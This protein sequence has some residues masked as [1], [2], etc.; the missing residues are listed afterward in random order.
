MWQ[1]IRGESS[2]SNGIGWIFPREF[3]RE[4]GRK[5]GRPF[6]NQRP[7]ELLGGRKVDGKRRRAEQLGGGGCVPRISPSEISRKISRT[8]KN[9]ERRRAL[10]ERGRKS[11]STD[12]VGRSPT[13]DRRCRRRRGWRTNLGLG[14]ASPAASQG[15]LAAH[16]PLPG[17]SIPPPHEKMPCAVVHTP[18]PT[19]PRPRSQ[20]SL[21]PPRPATPAD[22]K[23]HSPCQAPFART[24]RSFAP[25]ERRRF[26][27]AQVTDQ[28]V[29]QARSVAAWRRPNSR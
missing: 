3:P 28:R 26:R 9:S 21:Q 11:L 16:Y 1:E 23:P 10:R 12:K 13:A 24:T 17:I 7:V 18:P 19:H 8:D 2:E 29:S 20:T 15:N 5:S 6:G 27:K 22:S 14:C 25:G 4:D